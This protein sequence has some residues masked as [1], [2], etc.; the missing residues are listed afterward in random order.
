[1]ANWVGIF[2]KRDT[3]SKDTRSSSTST[4]CEVIN[5]AK[6]KELQT[7]C[8]VLPTKG[9]RMSTRCLERAYVGDVTKETIGLRGTSGL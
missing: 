8:S 3:T 6:S 1:M 5:L 9:D 7:W 2:V 4:V